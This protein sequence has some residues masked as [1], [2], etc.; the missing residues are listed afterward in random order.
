[1]HTISGTFRTTVVELNY[2]IS[3]VLTV[4]VFL[5]LKQTLNLGFVILNS[6]RFLLTG[7]KFKYMLK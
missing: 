5:R 4:N 3:V 2:S 1:M 7:H 6:F